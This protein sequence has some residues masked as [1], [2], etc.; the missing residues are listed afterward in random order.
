MPGARKALLIATDSHADPT[1]RELQAPPHDV[2]ALREVLADE[3][4]GNFAVAVAENTPVRDLRVEIERFFSRA[5][6]DDLLLLYFSGH[7]VKDENGDLHLVVTDTERDLLESTGIGAAFVRR[8]IDRSPARRVVLWLDCCYGGAFPPGKTPKAA[9]RVDVLDQLTGRSGRG[10]AVMTASTHLGYAYETREGRAASGAPEPSVFT[11]VI[12]EGLRTGEADLGGDGLV[13]VAELYTYVHDRVRAIAPAQAPTRNDQL[14][15]D[16]YIAR[17]PAPRRPEPEAAEEAAVPARHRGRYALAFGGVSVV[18]VAVAVFLANSPGDHRGAAT[19]PPPPTSPGTTS[20][21]AEPSGVPHLMYASGDEPAYPYTWVAL[22]VP[23]QFQG[24]EGAD[25]KAWWKLRGARTLHTEFRIDP[26]YL[27]PTI[28]FKVGGTFSP[29]TNCG[30]VHVEAR[31]GAR[32]MSRTLDSPDA[33][34][35]L[36]GE[37]PAIGTNDTFA[38]D[39]RVVQPSAGCE[40]E[41]RWEHITLTRVP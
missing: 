1:F 3:H 34:L 23:A 12:A 20:G 29:N 31:V 37:L 25:A 40:G 28:K 5:E 24:G 6:R 11:R 30:P 2:A 22:D 36:P 15:G 32:K 19:T 35:A 33:T 39:A 16:V 27:V 13:D 8:L 18:A 26:Y 38:V 4:I 17:S 21:S 10:C 7:G 14:T 41:L 9:S